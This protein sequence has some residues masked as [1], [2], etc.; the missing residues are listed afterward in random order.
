MQVFFPKFSIPVALH[1][2]NLKYATSKLKL[3]YERMDLTG[4]TVKK[5]PMS[6]TT[7][8]YHPMLNGSYGFPFLTRLGT[9]EHPMF[10]EGNG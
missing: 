1:M 5:T 7:V 10:C 9:H 2:E 8:G 4:I 3:I 6:V